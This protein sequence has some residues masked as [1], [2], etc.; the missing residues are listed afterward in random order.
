MSAIRVFRAKRIVTLNPSRPLATHVAVRDGR[1]LG[2]GGAELETA[3]GAATLDDRLAD[4][5]LLPG[6]VE[7]HGHAT[8]GSFWRHPYVG[9]FARTA[10]DGARQGGYTSI[11]E[12]VAAL[13]A[14]EPLLADA[15]TPLIAWGFDPIY[16]E[17]R[18]MT[19]ADLD[20]ISPTRPIIVAHVSGHI[21]NV[22]S[23]VLARAGFSRD[24]NLDGLLRDATGA[25]T[26]ELLG[27]AVMGRAARVSG[28]PVLLRGLDVA[29]LRGFAAT[30]R[31][32]GVTTSTDLVNELSPSQVGALQTATAAADFP[33]R[34]VPAMAARFY[35][36][37]TGLARLAALREQSSAK[38]HFGLVKL[39]VDGSI[40]GFTARLH[41]ADA[42]FAREL[43][44]S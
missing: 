38:L 5:V 29:D 16:F 23:A 10:P 8:T 7:G 43:R 40:Q 39:V 22:N 2:V 31:R 14:R 37:P 36:L 19:V 20:A 41:S 3:L 18:R 15:E 35:D 32:V 4:K 12:V 9:Y 25:L 24:S 21:M 6:F 27:P 13:K 44:S 34:L 33:L 28:D 42:F 26:G 11:A 17:G 30:C 1:I